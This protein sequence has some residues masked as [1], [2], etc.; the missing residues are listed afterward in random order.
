MMLPSNVPNY[1][2]A[3]LPQEAELTPTLISE[4]CQTLKR[5][6]QQYL[7]GRTTES[8]IRILNRLGRDWQS[9]D[10]PF[11]Q[12]VLQN[13]PAHTGFSSEVLA[14]GLDNF[15]RLWT[16]ENIE[17]LLR[18]EL[19]HAHRL[20]DFTPDEHEGHGGR[21]AM[22]LGPTLLAHIAPG[23]IPVPVLMEMLLGLLARSAQFIKCASGQEFIP[24][25]F[26]HSLYE[27]D[28]KLGACLELAS[29]KGGAENLEAALFAEADCVVAT[30]SDKT[31]T[32]IRRQL[33][34]TARFIGY[35][36]KLSF[37]YVTREAMERDTPAVVNQAAADVTAWNQRGCLSPHVLYVEDTGA[38]GE[39][40]ANLLAGKLESLE[41]SHPRG[42]LSAR[43]AAGIATRRAFYEVRAAHSPETKMW[44]SREST[45]WTVIMEL[46]PRFQISCQNRFIY[47]KLV[48]DLTLAL[49]GAEPVRE[50]VSTVGLACAP[51]Q[52]AELARRL[53]RWGAKR[54]CPLGQMQHPPLG[55]RHDG[56]PPL[57]DLV[58]WI[59]WEKHGK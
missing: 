20:D 9:A 49:Q 11:R 31:L 39:E 48:P 30:G 23:N 19:G 57:G 50:H 14:A 5:N 38:S 6:R 32:A 24:R 40:F 53:A 58:T 36:E 33:P 12:Q 10:F 52:A 46:D 43:D 2:L 25:M 56:R 45:A 1:F 18:Q 37:G 55:W 16:T 21:S 8:I 26:A 27:A 42:P 22:A 51:A 15:F 17:A 44:A 35:G 3:D 41:K 7:E 59:D 28:H 34:A 4:A 13:G 29:W 54:I 47:V